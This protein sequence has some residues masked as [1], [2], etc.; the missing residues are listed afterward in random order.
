[1]VC[2]CSRYMIVT[3]LHTKSCISLLP[4]EPLLTPGLLPVEFSLIP[5]PPTKAPRPLVP[6]TAGLNPS[7]VVPPFLSLWDLFIPVL[8]TSGASPS[9]C[10]PLLSLA[11]PW[12]HSPVTVLPSSTGPYC[13]LSVSPLRPS[14]HCSCAPRLA[15]QLC[16]A[17]GL[18][19]AAPSRVRAPLVACR[20]LRPLRRRGRTRRPA[21]PD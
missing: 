11:F 3:H 8:T 12:V 7:S 20:L 19:L 4:A 5:L 1:M 10:P 9:S 14:P 6:S 16:R 17:A 21:Y 13:V 15:A 18:G 2:R